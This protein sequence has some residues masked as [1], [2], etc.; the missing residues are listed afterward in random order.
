MSRMRDFTRF[1]VVTAAVALMSIPKASAAD[2][3]KVAAAQHGTWPSAVAEL[4]QRVGVFKR[5]GLVLEFLF[6]RDGNETEQLVTSGSADVGLATNAMQV[7]RA[8]AFG[9]P[10][11][12]ISTHIAGSTNY[13][14]VPRSSPIHSF[15]DIA[16]KTVGYETNGASSQYDAIDL[17][18]KYGLNA[19]LVLTGGANATFAHVKAGI[20]DIG[21]G[22]PPFGVDRIAR[23]DI[24]VIARAN[25]VPQIRNKT[26]SV[27]ITNANTLER[28]KDV[29]ARY[30]RAY[31]E[32]IEWMYS[33]P[34]ALERYA[35]LADVSEGEARQLRDEFFPKETLLPGNVVGLNMIAKDA[36]VLGYLRKRLSRRQI[37][38]LV[39]IVA[40]ALDG[41]V[42]CKDISGACAIAPPAP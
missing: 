19:K 42:S 37:K 21:W 32:A 28:R 27:I 34:A 4:G 40:P 10:L 35:E 11:R 8:Y 15:A 36:V 1:V 18:R 9:A 33:D 16:G 13:W 26:A 38:K 17:M 12:I 24:R 5:H 25:N 3:L 31:R 20:I 39:Q 7:M 23:G 41:Q 14:Y 29:L 6:T 22:A 30:L 2:V